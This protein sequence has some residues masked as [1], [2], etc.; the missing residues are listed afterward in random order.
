MKI[1]YSCA[2][3]GLGHAARLACL[4]PLLEQQFEV[5]YYVPASVL[6]YV[7]GRLPGRTIRPL[8]WFAFEKKGDRVLYWATFFQALRRSVSMLGDVFSLARDLEAQGIEAVLSDY[9]PYL[10]WAGWFQGLRVVQFNHPGI[11]SRRLTLDPRCWAAALVG[12]SM[13]GPWNRRLHV[14][15]YIGDVG[16]LIRPELLARK[17]SRRGP[18]VLHLKPEYRGPVLAALDR[19]GMTDYELFP[20]KGGDFDG[21]LA[22]CRGVISS[23]GHQI[24]SEALVLGK[25]I[26]VLPQTGQYEQALNAKMLARARR[27]MRSSLATL[28]RDLTRF[29]LWAEKFVCLDNRYRDSSAL[30]VEKLTKALTGARTGAIIRGRRAPQWKSAE[31]HPVAQTS[32]SPSTN[33][34]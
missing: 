27:G 14:S 23:A 9:D 29:R 19:A 10:A 21:A 20:R 31:P 6:S 30:A 26:L 1:A 24:I 16:P 4:G 5:V 32:R 33:A 17:R 3:E 25:P 12:L 34:S 2:G 11:V 28:D 15:F 22:R 13:E 8:P 18:W 7:E